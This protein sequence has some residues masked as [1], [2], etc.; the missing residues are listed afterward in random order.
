VGGVLVLLAGAFDMLDGPLARAKGKTTTFGAMLDSSL[1]R[2]SEAA[3]LLG[4][5]IYFLYH[6]GTWEIWLP[7][8]TFVASVQRSLVLA[9][10][11]SLDANTDH[12]WSFVTGLPLASVQPEAVVSAFLMAKCRYLGSRSPEPFVGQMMLGLKIQVFERVGSA[13]IAS[14]SQWSSRV[15][16]MDDVVELNELFGGTARRVPITS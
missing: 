4:I 8:V 7:Y 14:R 10:T 1:D 2:L 13:I 12:G 11:A 5:L 16:R 6:E 3:V 15:P 9:V